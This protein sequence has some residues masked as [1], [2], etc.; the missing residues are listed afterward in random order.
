MET[1]IV[2]P[3]TGKYFLIYQNNFL[4]K[5]QINSMISVWHLNWHIRIR[6][7]KFENHVKELFII[8]EQKLFKEWSIFF[9]KYFWTVYWISIVHNA[10]VIC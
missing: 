3:T 8:I 9:Y 7:I 10:N 1:R 5:F 2:F 6:I 4:V